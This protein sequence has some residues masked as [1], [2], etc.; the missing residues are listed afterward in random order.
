MADETK[1]TVFRFQIGRVL[2]SKSLKQ[3]QSEQRTLASLIRH[4]LVRYLE[5]QRRKQG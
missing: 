2:L 1:T 3:A 5:D 4:L